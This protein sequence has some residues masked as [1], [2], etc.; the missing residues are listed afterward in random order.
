MKN[1]I[2]TAVMLIIF[3]LIFNY[4]S[5]NFHLLAGWVMGAIM[6]VYLDFDRYTDDYL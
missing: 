4:V 1:I 6:Y 5:V 3:M 2:L